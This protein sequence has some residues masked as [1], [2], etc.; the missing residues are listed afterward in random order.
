MNF[1][2]SKTKMIPFKVAENK[3]SDLFLDWIILGDNTP[4]DVA[5]KAKINGSKKVYYPIR[6]FTIKYDAEWSATSIWEHKEEYTEYQSK[7]VYIDYYG[8]EHDKAGFD[9]FY[10]GSR[11]GTS[12]YG[13][14]NKRPWTPQQKMVPIKKHKTVIDKIEQTYGQI[15]NQQSS[16]SIITYGNM[17]ESKLSEW[18]VGMGINNYIDSD[19]KLIENCEVKSLVESDDSALSRAISRVR[20]EASTRCKHQIPGNR[21]ENFGI[22]NLYYDY[23]MKIILLPVYE[24]SYECYGQD[25][26]CWIS[27]VSEKDIFYSS[28]PIDEN[29]AKEYKRLDEKIKKSKKNDF[30]N[31]ILSLGIIPVFLVFGFLTLFATFLVGS[32]FIRTLIVVGIAIKFGIEFFKRFKNSRQETKELTGLKTNYKSELEETRKQILDIVRN[33]TID[34]KEKEKQIKEI[35]N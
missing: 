33:N 13:G 9:D 31:G 2:I 14:K 1:D 30:L 29:I 12:S 25:F 7:T 26:K 23:A 35:L 34:E 21:Y 11:I 18:I 10:K 28:K 19:M 22:D 3:I 27:G 4:L 24:V 8:K 16:H 5:Y 32:G 15:E 20:S 6:R 17:E